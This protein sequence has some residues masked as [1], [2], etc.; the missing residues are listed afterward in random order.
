[1]PNMQWQVGS[2]HPWLKEGRMGTT[3]QSLFHGNCEPGQ[4]HVPVPTI[5]GPEVGGITGGDLWRQYIT[6]TK[7][8][9]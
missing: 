4:T 9:S 2:G 1:M 7:V 3:W 6:D 8:F 5:L